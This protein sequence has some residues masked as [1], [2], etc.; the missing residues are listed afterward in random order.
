MS[1]M[2]PLKPRD[3]VHCVIVGEPGYPPGSGRRP[4][5]TQRTVPACEVEDCPQP[6]TQ[7]HGFADNLIQTCDG[8]AEAVMLALLGSLG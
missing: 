5:D 6:A 1:G 4:V 2:P 8:H 7:T 3:S